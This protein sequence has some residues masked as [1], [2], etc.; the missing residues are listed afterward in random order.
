MKVTGRVGVQVG[1]AGVRTT[2]TYLREVDD[3]F[4]AGRIFPGDRL[5]VSTFTSGQKPEV[6]QLRRMSHRPPCHAP[7]PCG[8]LTNAIDHSVS[9][10]SHNNPPQT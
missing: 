3:P 5:L 7:N 9:P 6:T 4:C 10:K 1:L 2:E 8:R